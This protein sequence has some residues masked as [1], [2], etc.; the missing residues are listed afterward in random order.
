MLHWTNLE[1]EVKEGD[2]NE[3]QN[4]PNQARFITEIYATFI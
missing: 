4:A 1:V 3:V 2:L